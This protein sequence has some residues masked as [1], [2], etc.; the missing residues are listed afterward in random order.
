MRITLP[1]SRGRRREYDVE[2]G[3]K[4][5]KVGDGGGN[6]LPLVQAN[7]EV[8]KE[9]TVQR[10]LPDHERHCRLFREEGTVPFS[11]AVGPASIDSRIPSLTGMGVSRD[12][13][14]RSAPRSMSVDTFLGLVSK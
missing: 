11:L 10:R 12:I 8:F 6:Q 1:K 4:S 14:L 5:R 7:S 13:L 9:T 2:E 3:N